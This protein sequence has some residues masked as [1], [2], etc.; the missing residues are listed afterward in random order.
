MKIA[1]LL[2]STCTE[3]RIKQIPTDYLDS[4]SACSQSMNAKGGGGGGG[5]YLC[6]HWA[7]IDF[8]SLLHLQGSCRPASF[9]LVWLS[10]KGDLLS[11]LFSIAHAVTVSG[12]QYFFFLLIGM[13]AASQK[14]TC[15]IYS[16]WLHLASWSSKSASAKLSRKHACWRGRPQRGSS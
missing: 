1:N 4:K 15:I 6:S 10:H 3:S 16:P 9:T 11:F 5:G 12:F 2:L 13:V 8:S 14:Y 7:V